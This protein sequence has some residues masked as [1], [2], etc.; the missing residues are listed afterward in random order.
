[1]NSHFE[2]CLSEQI[3]DLAE[4]GASGVEWQAGALAAEV[5]RGRRTAA[6][7]PDGAAAA[8]SACVFPGFSAY[9]PAAGSL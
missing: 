3:E 6:R 5:A 1:M 9:A 4:T 7:S 2:Q 8:L